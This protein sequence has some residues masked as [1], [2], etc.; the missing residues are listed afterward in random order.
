MGSAY[1]AIGGNRRNRRPWLGVGVTPHVQDIDWLMHRDAQDATT[2]ASAISSR[3]DMVEH[4]QMC[5]KLR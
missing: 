5:C 4:E 2:M 1:G 3:S